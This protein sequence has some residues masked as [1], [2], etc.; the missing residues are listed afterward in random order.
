[1]NKNLK[2]TFLSILAILLLAFMTIVII[3]K[4]GNIFNVFAY[5]NE[6]IFEKEYNGANV[7]NLDIISDTS[8]III[9][10]N[11]SN[12]IKVSIYGRKND[13][14]K[15]EIKDDYLYIDNDKKINFCIGFC[16]NTKIEVLLPE[17]EYNKLKIK[18]ISGDI[19]T[20]NIS[21]NDIT[22]SSTSGEIKINKSSTAAIKTISGDIVFIEL[23]DAE[24]STTSGEIKGDTVD[25][26]TAKTISGDIEISKINKYCQMTTT[27]G[28]I[29]ISS[30]TLEKDSL[31]KSISGDIKISKANSIY[32]DTSTISGDIDVDND[33]HA[34]YE[35]KIK[36][37]SGDINVS[38]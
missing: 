1:M 33:R 28:E 29:T 24:I 7:K 16:P 38:K 17:K 31:L 20:S 32:V 13:D 36:T 2:I 30:L 15:V 10:K 27:S 11:E 34:K 25:K 3:D 4:D 37:T 19:D 26:I 14:Y 8:N 23:N 18:T 12:V 22:V 21:S 35:L 5:S 9:K 6:L